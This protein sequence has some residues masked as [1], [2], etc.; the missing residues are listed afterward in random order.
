MKAVELASM[1]Y[2]AK[3]A[4]VELVCLR[5]IAFFKQLCV[6]TGDLG[7]DTVTDFERSKSEVVQIYF[8]I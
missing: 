7:S 2:A 4:V 8:L 1:C 6:Y 3:I 5:H